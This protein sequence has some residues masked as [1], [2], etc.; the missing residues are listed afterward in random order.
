MRVTDRLAEFDYV[1]EDERGEEDATVWRLQG[2]PYDIQ[3]KVQK[4]IEPRVHL[5]ASAVGAGE[6][7]LSDALGDSKVEID[8]VGGRASLEFEILNAGLIS[9]SNLIGADGNSVDY[10]GTKAPVA[11]KKEWFAR[12]LPQS[13]RTELCNAITEVSV[14][15]GDEAKN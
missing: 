8:I 3:Q 6:Q 12:W 11:K 9:V 1:L 7:A 15:E 2:L 10:P 14:M 13:V 5:P 4:A